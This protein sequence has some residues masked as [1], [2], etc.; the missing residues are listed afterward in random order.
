MQW[1]ITPVLPRLRVGLLVRWPAAIEALVLRCDAAEAFEFLLLA[2]ID[3][4]LDHI[5]DQ[6]TKI[7]AVDARR[8]VLRSPVDL[9][10]N[11]G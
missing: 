7:L 8:I 1:S 11:A 3:L 2:Q 4:D 10:R 6:R 5:I 9:D